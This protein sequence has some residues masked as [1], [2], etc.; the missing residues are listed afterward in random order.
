[1]A[2]DLD[3][4]VEDRAK[5]WR[6]AALEAVCDVIEPWEHG[7][8]AR[9][10]GYPNYFDFNLVRV[11]DDPGMSVEQLVAFA[12]DA[13]AGLIHRR[14]DF[15]KIEAAD[16]RRGEF[17]ALGWRSLRLVWMRYEPRASGI[18]HSSVEE[19]PY[20]EV[21]DLRLTWYAEDHP[22]Q[23]AGGYHD[24]AR[25]VA[26]LRHARVL[27]TYDDGRPVAFA[28]LEHDGDGAEITQVY[29][30]PD[31]RG[32]GQGTAMTIAAIALAGDVRDLWIAAD[33][34][35][36]PKELYARLGFRPAWRSMEITRWP[37][38]GD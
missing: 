37:G 14:F 10:T 9:A 31:H 13:L 11:E 17:E 24:Q 35:D 33:D 6:T 34:E 15:D 27:A 36:R 19:V 23:I 25:D 38:P 18:A 22:D 16:R 8:I 20:D 30:H 7:T 29:V 12:D 1:M 5:A 32:K 4:S 26:M 28:Q 3:P 21:H 2:G